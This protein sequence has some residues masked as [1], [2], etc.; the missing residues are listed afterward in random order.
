[1]RRA[2]ET[3]L[4]MAGL[5]LAALPAPAGA[6]SKGGGDPAAKQV[7]E[8]MR[9]ILRADYEAD[10]ATLK[11]EF[12]AL[13]KQVDSPEVGAEARYWRGFARWRAGINGWN[14][15]MSPTEIA[16]HTAAAADEFAKAIERDP[17]FADAR[18]AMAICRATLLFSAQPE[19]ADKMDRLRESS[20]QLKR[21]LDESPENPRTLWLVGGTY[22][23]T[24]PE[25]GGS[26][27]K[28]VSIYEKGLA[29]ARRAPAADAAPLRP[30]WGEPELLMSLAYARLKQ[31]TPDL[32]AAEKYAREA[33]ARVPYWHYVRDI[34]MKQIDAARAAVA[35]APAAT[36]TP[37]LSTTPMR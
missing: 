5:I 36:P 21:A 4:M 34:L 12:D 19:P 14:D 23:W 29:A 13:K 2:V 10:Q 6:A 32:D 30:T 11:R 17:T 15:G 9:R 8:S 35:T 22:F 16:E 24:P 31:P 26:V 3:F 18:A 20:S 28:A 37:S 7:A 33:L 1:M 25:Q 27:D